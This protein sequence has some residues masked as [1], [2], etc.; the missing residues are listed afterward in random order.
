MPW[1]GSTGDR[2][3]L[4]A[5]AR[6]A[7]ASMAPASSL[8]RL[9]MGVDSDPRFVATA[10]CSLP[11]ARVSVSDLGVALLLG[12]SGWDLPVEVAAVVDSVFLLL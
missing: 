6:Y 3:C 2:K 5:R 8:I 1:Q 12:R 9:V 7:V 11:G 10:A 4:M